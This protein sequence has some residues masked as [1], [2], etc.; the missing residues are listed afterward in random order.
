[1]EKNPQENN[2]SSH[3]ESFT[4]KFLEGDLTFWV[5][6]GGGGHD[7]EYMVTIEGFDTM[8]FY[9]CN[10]VASTL[11]EMIG[12]EWL[13][14][15]RG[16]RIEIYKKDNYG[17]RDDQ[18]IEESIKLAVKKNISELNERKNSNSS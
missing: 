2:K 3:G 1:M 4:H 12:E 5:Q 13:V 14:S 17:D 16:T 15:S 7:G 6:F 18:K 10:T 9:P 8:D 11:K